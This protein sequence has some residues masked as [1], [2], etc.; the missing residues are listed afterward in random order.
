MEIYHNPLVVTMMCLKLSKNT[1]KLQGK[2]KAI[3]NFRQIRRKMVC[4]ALSMHMGVE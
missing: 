3:N 4:K 2:D 1:A